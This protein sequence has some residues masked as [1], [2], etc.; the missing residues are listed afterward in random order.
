M[1]MSGPGIPAI[2]LFGWCVL[3]CVFQYMLFDLVQECAQICGKGD[4][5]LTRE[6]FLSLKSGH[7]VNDISREPQRKILLQVNLIRLAWLHVH[8]LKFV[9]GKLN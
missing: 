8:T 1:S 9:S 7:D 3:C 2:S 6:M 5:N 4:S